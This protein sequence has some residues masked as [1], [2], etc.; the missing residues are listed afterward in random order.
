MSATP[1]EA[2]Y[3]S[4]KGRPSHADTHFVAVDL[5]F[6]RPEGLTRAAAVPARLLLAGIVAVSFGLRF[7]AAL[8]HTTPL[9]FPDEYIYGSIARSLAETGR[10]LIR[11]H[12]AHFPAMLEP[13][14][15][16][17][18]WLTHDPTVAYRLTQ[19]ENALAMSLAAIPVYLLVRRLGG[20]SWPALAAG[21]LTVASPDLFFASF[22]LADA[23]AYPLVLG[24][25]YLGVCALSEP[26]RR[27]QIGFA[28]LAG[29]ATFTRVQYV[30]LPVV[31]IVAALV[32]ESGSVRTVWRRFRLSLGLY[33]A[34][35][36]LVAVLGPKR[37]LGYYSGVADLGVK[38]SAIGH[39]LG[40]DALLLAYSAGFALVPG[41]LVGLAYALRRPRT[42]DENAFA[43]LAVGALL[44][45]FVEASLYAASGTDRFQERYLMVLPPLVLPAFALWLRRNRPGARVAAL[46]GLG[47]VAL[48]ARVPL[49]G[50]TISDSKQDSP[51]LLAVF[52]LEKGIGIGTGS[53]VVAL[54]A[55]ALALLGAAVC[56][57]AFLARWAIGATILAAAFVSLGAVAFDAHVVR[58]VRTSLLPPDAR[59]V[60]HAGLGGVS[61]IQTPATLHAAVNEQLFWN[62]SLKH[63]Y[64]LDDASPI[65]AFGSE[66]VRAARDGRLVSKGRTLRGPLLIS[67]YA[68]RVKLSGA[69]AVGHGPNYDL[70][71]A[72]G[73]PRFALFAGGLYQD[74]WLSASGHM[75]VWPAQNGRVRG[76]L[77]LPLSLPPKP[78]SETTTLQLRGPGVTR[79]VTVH[80]GQSI[81]VRLKVSH[82]GPWTLS[83]RTKRPGYLSDGRPISVMAQMPTFAGIYCGQNTANSTATVA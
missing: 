74:G 73:T 35:L 40:T 2:K 27:L 50:Y 45:I 48:A 70:Y 32:V 6:P 4:F 63:L 65:D 5:S 34:P 77:T 54:L 67:N 1:M 3:P 57:R 28:V 11:G 20:G 47:L 9:Y 43:A 58:S 78:R 38:P 23:I 42:R 24:A 64:F 56:Y 76:V 21:A 10:P 36:L 66:R 19:A 53:L 83:F 30:F 7:A 75:T 18:F 12:S 51:F 26:T 41:A 52:R 80:P 46:L 60:D 8:V 71:R 14:L 22:V 31:F 25:I 59:W 17:P 79:N 37:L 44:A 13:L 49:S 68:V 15:A 81:V 69:V 61:M 72:L 16:A 33:A 29:L 39:W 82:R 55:S 62:L